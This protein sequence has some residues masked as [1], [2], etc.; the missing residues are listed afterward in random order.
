MPTFKL[1][2]A[3]GSN[4]KIE[5]GN[6]GEEYLAVIMH[7]KPDT[8]ICPWSADCL[9]SCLNTAGRG[10]MFKKGELTNV[11]QEARARKSNLFKT[12][13]AGF[14]AL[15]Y[16]DI[17]KA[18]KYATKLGLQLVVRLNGTSDIPFEGI[19]FTVDGVQYRNIFAAFPTVRFYD[20]TKG[21]KRK[22]AGIENYSLTYSRQLANETQTLELLK[23][24]QNVAVVF[25][26][27]PDH[28]K[29]Y[30]VIN[31]DLTDLRFNDPSG[32][33]V[34]LKAKGKA[35]K[36]TSGFVVMASTNNLIRTVNV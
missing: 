1:L 34:G 9:A 28:W 14:M 8:E 3:I 27:L 32:V 12:D 6:G 30:T 29:G 16:A 24:G 25:D 21:L 10:G 11:I 4:P 20:Y 19:R 13:R 7:L 22:I 18:E 26:K 2:S 17:L 35:K 33:I 23:A 36:D 5:K 15:L 31:G